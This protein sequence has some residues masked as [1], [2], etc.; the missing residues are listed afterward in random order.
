MSKITRRHRAED[1]VARSSP[2]ARAPG[3][4]TQRLARRLNPRADDGVTRL[5]MAPEGSAMSASV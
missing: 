5:D 1:D 2:P 4:T 3:R